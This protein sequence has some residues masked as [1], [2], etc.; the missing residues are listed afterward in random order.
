MGAPAVDNPVAIAL[1]LALSAFWIFCAVK[2]AMNGRWGLFV[3]GWFC[4]IAWVIG[5]FS[6]SASGGGSGGSVKDY[7]KMRRR[8][9]AGMAAVPQARDDGRCPAC[10]KH[11]DQTTGRCGVCGFFFG[12]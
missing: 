9:G 11:T 4:G 5:A 8:Q 3:L 6:G 12:C 7:N 10:G 2:T 1:G